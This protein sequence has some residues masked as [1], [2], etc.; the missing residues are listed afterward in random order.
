MYK[1]N[2][3]G[4]QVICNMLFFMLHG[5]HEMANQSSPGGGETTPPNAPRKSPYE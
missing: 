4:V 5:G 3:G 2:L 1:K